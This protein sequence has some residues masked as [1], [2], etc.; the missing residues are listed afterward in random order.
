MSN[1]NGLM[2]WPQSDEDVTADN[3][4]RYNVQRA[5]LMI[6][7]LDVYPSSGQDWRRAIIALIDA[8]AQAF[9]L[10][11]L[12]EVAPDKADGIA[13]DLHGDIDDGGSVHEWVWQW[14]DEYGMDFEAIKADAKRMA[15]K[16]MAAGK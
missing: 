3:L 15:E 11:K 6:E 8:Y 2:M 5:Q 13:R 16:V 14:A 10:R 9:L 12:I 1:E 4:A 7:A